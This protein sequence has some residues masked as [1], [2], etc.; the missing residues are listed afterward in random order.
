M[1]VVNLKVD[2]MVGLMCILSH[3][4]LVSYLK[5][6]VWD[7]C[8]RWDDPKSSK[9]KKNGN[10]KEIGNDFLFIFVKIWDHQVDLSLLIVTPFFVIQFICC[11]Y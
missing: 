9:I 3:F 7:W 5:R 10:S 6:V 2:E 8:E 4:Q 11:T 1:A